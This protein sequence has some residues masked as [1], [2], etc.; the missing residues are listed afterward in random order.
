[1]DLVPGASGHLCEQFSY[2]PQTRRLI[3]RG[4]MAKCTYDEL[5]AL[6]SDSHHRQAVERL[7]VLSSAELRPVRARRP[8]LWA[9]VLAVVLV[10]AAIFVWLNLAKPLTR[11]AKCRGICLP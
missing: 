5:I 3:F 11:N 8:H 9:W 4:F 10:L 6:H 1:M 2:V 7:F